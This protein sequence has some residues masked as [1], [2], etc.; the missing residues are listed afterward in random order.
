MGGVATWILVVL[1]F[2]IVFQLGS[3]ADKLS[4]IAEALSQR[5]HQDRE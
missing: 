5:E 4:K 1:V 2:L 3:I